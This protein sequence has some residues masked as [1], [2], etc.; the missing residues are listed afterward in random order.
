MLDDL[1][2]AV[3]DDRLPP[4]VQAALVHAQFETIHPFGDGNG[5]AG[6]A[7]IHV[8][9]RRRGVAPRF[10]PPIS[11]VFASAR[12]R[13]IAG[14]TAFRGDAVTQWVEQFAVAT[15]RAAA[16]AEAYLAELKTLRD[17]WRRRLA[18]RADA[19][20][21]DAAAW[22]IID[23]LPGHPIVTGPLIEELTGR[24]KG[25]VYPAIDQ[26]VA[27]GVLSPTSDSKR[28]RSWEAVGLL[29]IIERLEAGEAP[30]Q[31]GE[32]AVQS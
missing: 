31:P 19:P 3:E 17:D 10:V 16:L 12:D 29:P 14:L 21:E 15:A 25:A 23:Q 27:A 26:L 20:R 8:V 9:L 2:V 11:V 32:S 5:R 24:A 30:E 18:E 22:K 7:L 13:Y 6:R 1:C 4:L 28:N